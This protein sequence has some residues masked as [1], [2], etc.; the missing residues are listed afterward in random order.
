MLGDPH[1]Q[2]SEQTPAVMGPP[3]RA[4][5]RH[6]CWKD[7]ISPSP[8]CIERRPCGSRTNTRCHPAHGRRGWADAHGSAP[9]LSR[10]RPG[11]Y[12]RRGKRGRT[13]IPR[14]RNSLPLCVP[15]SAGL[16]DWRAGFWKTSGPRLGPTGVRLGPKPARLDAPP[17]TRRAPPTSQKKSRH[18]A[19]QGEG[20]M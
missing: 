9:S 13:R 15:F 18:G 11:S 16:R 20:V 10:R 17:G 2:A 3:G 6:H 14:I 1:V 4:E 7:A 5:L 8:P 19:G 12:C